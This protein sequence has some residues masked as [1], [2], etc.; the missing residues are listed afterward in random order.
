MLLY[1][2][3]HSRPKIAFAVHQCT[4]YTFQPTHCHQLTLI[5]IRNYLIETI[6][7][8]LIMKPS[9]SPQV[10]CYLD[11][12]FGGLYGHKHHQDPHCAC[13]CMGYPVFAFGCP[14]LWCNC[15]QTE[16]VFSTMEVKYVA[17]STACKDLLTLL[18]LVCE[19]SAAVSLPSDIES[20]LYCQVHEDNIGALTLAGLEPCRMIPCQKHFAIKSLWICSPVFDPS[21]NNTIV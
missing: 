10:D 17:L 16:I 15:L 19:L 5:Q 11:A 3:G 7:Q 21:S 18:D 4:R 1:L 8:G 2:S 14:V 12:D 9:L 6:D 13:S 20:H